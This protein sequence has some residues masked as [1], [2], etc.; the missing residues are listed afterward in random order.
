[1]KA[2]SAVESGGTAQD[3]AE[4]LRYKVSTIGKEGKPGEQVRC[5][6][7]V[8][9]LSEG[10]DAANVT[11]ILGLRAFTSQL[12]CEQVVGRGLRRM[13]YDVDPATGL[14]TPEYVDVY[15]IPFQVIPVQ[16]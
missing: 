16:K 8:S 14:M 1:K 4:A 15:G 7:S 5:V 13:S 12:L 10:W 6:V 2:E 11:Q 3:A 9:M